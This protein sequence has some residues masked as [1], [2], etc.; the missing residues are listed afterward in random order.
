MSILLRT[1][2]AILLAVPGFAQQSSG[3]VGKQAAKKTEPAQKPE[4]LTVDGVIAMVQAGLSD[5]V[6]L[7]RLRK[8][9]KPFDLGANEMIRLKNAKVSDVVLKAMLDPKAEIKPPEPPAPAPAVVAQPVVIQSPTVPVIAGSNPSGATPAPG[10]SAAGDPNDP[11]TP[12]DSG[13]Y[14]YTKDRDGKPQ[15][16]VLERA[17]YQGAKTGG[18]FASAITYGVKK[19]KTRAV[20]PGEKAGIRITD[21]SP[22]FYFYFEDKATGLGKSHFGIGT[23][24]NPNQFVLLKLEINK[25]NRE[26]MIGEYSM[27]GS[28]SGSDAKAMVPFKSER[29]RPG[30]YKV[31]VE[32]MKAGEYC[33]LAYS[34]TP[35]AYAAAAGITGTADIFDF[36][37]SVE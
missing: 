17:S 37:V 10:A 28:S 29:I 36:G 19:V 3:N 31:T 14:L 24:D 35:G 23:L 9:D 2:I 5:D 27:W 13:V 15:M 34:S 1:S 25:S 18:M 21:A 12:H 30:L 8:Q 20:I 16:V 11:Q 26:T 33:F 22:V 7:A 32:G 6:I 4:T